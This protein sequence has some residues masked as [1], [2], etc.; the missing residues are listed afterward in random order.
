MKRLPIHRLLSALLSLAALPGL[1]GQA[2]PVVGADDPTALFTD[3]DPKLNTNKQAAMHIVLD[4]LECGH[5]NESDK[6]L[7]DQYIQH[8]PGFSSGRA[9][10]VA[11]FSKSAPREIPDKDHWRTKV[12]AVVAEGDYVSVATRTEAADPRNPGQTYTTTH[13]DMWRFVNG[14]ADEHWDEGRINAPGAGRGP[15][16][17]KQ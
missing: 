1:F 8:N 9:T 14:K 15:A 16:Q 4:L 13:F 5:W 6:W 7:T 12:V 11:A 17:A 2:A 3:K 10:V